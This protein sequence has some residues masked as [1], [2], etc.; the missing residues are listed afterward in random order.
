MKFCVSFNPKTDTIQDMNTTPE[1]LVD[2]KALTGEGPAW[3]VCTRVLYW[4]D[5]PNATI[6]VYDPRSGENKVYDLSAQF[7]SIGTV[8]PR[9]SGGVI[10]T[11][12]RKIAA[13][14]LESG[15]VTIL[16]EVEPELPGNRF[17]DGKCDPYG[18]FVGGTMKSNSDG[19]ACGALYIL[20]TDLSLRKLRDGLVISN[21][22]GWSPDYR[23]FYLA[24]S[25]SR[26][27]WVYDYDLERGEIANQRVVITLP[28]GL[29]VADGMTVDCD[30]YIWLALWDGACI[31]RWNPKTGQMLAK[32]DFPAKRT[33]CCAFGGDQLRDL[34]VTSAAVGLTD[35]DWQV[36]PNNGALMRIRTPY[37]GMPAFAFGG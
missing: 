14:D 25:A 12:E 21:G 5:I 7:T 9:E 8:A 3:D 27:V 1:I 22:L 13:L 28:D 26:D 16:A 24:D 6:F 29:G 23:L 17:N 33:S 2:Q 31:T 10:F 4:V 11:P 15:V 20:D 36:Y 34:Y 35:E 18:R 30:G 19:E 37:Q 32:Y